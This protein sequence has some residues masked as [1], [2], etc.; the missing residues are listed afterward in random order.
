MIM[1]FPTSLSVIKRRETLMNNNTTMDTGHQAVEKVVQLVEQYDRVVRRQP[2]NGT[3][4]TDAEKKQALYKRCPRHLTAYL[5][6]FNHEDT[7]SFSK[8][9][10]MVVTHDMA[11]AEDRANNH[12]ETLVSAVK[13][14]PFDQDS[15]PAP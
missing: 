15:S 11:M 12:S 6:P 2:Y 9:S 1:W 4:L 10:K 7:V 13:K 5:L 8:F 14:R 3:Y